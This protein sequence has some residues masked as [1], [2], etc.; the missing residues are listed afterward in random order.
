[1]SL[2]DKGSPQ[3]SISALGERIFTAGYAGRDP[4]RLLRIAQALDACVVDIRLKPR[5]RAPQWQRAALARLLGGRYA[6]CSRLGNL[7]YSTGGPVEIWDLDFGLVSLL[8]GLT[9]FP[10]LILLCA[11]R[12]P[13]GCHRTVVARALADRHGI[14]TREL[15][16]GEDRCPRL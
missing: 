1:M 8:E 13:Q 16:W 10:R 7:N 3:G 6:L 11:C 15:D 9:L 14:H 4:H 5:S 12:E 2:E